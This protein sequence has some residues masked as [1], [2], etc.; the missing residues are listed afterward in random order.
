MNRNTQI[1]SFKQKEE[2]LDPRGTLTSDG[3]QSCSSHGFSWL[4]AR[5]DAP[6]MRF[7]AEIRCRYIA[8]TLGEVRFSLAIPAF[9]HPVSEGISRKPLP[10]RI[11]GA[12]R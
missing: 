10:R 3:A 12:V 1:I 7:D 9:P 2:V 8:N 5:L 11:W 6:S 4:T